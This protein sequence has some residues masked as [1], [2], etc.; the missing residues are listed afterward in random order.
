V[1]DAAGRSGIEVCS[2]KK[3]IHLHFWVI[4]IGSCSTFVLWKLGSIAFKLFAAIDLY[5][6]N[7][8]HVAANRSARHVYAAEFENIGRNVVV[9]SKSGLVET[10]PNVLVATALRVQVKS[11]GVQRIEAL[12]M[13]EGPTNGWL[14]SCSSMLVLLLLQVSILSMPPIVTWSKFGTLGVQLDQKADG[15]VVLVQIYSACTIRYKRCLLYCGRDM[16]PWWHFFCA[17]T[18]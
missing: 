6:V 3:K 4:R 5:S 14:H 18:W 16:V 8:G 2:V 17:Y 1:G 10:R 7:C 12:D 11:P 15:R 9:A 13:Q